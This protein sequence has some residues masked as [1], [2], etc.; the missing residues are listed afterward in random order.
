[1]SSFI[2]QHTHFILSLPPNNNN[3][4]LAGSC[5]KTCI[6]YR[7]DVINQNETHIM[8]HL[9]ESSSIGTIHRFALESRL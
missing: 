4:S 1:M 3:C 6:V 8:V 7:A 9:I 5:M 2:K